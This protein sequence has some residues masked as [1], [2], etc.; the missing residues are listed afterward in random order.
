MRKIITATFITLDGVMQAPGGPE[1]DTS[2]GFKYGGWQA[3]VQWDEMMSSLLNTWMG[4]PFELL[5]G[6][7]TY[8]IF[9]A[10]WP[11]D[12][13]SPVVAKPFNSTKKYVVSHTAF[14]LSWH[15]SVC[16]TG[17]DVAVQIKKLKEEDGP[18]LWVWGSGNLIQT[19]L[20]HHLIDRMYLWIYPITIGSG[21]RLF[22]EGTQAEKF[23]L[24]DSKISTS[25]VIIA[26]YEPAGELKKGLSII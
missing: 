1:E 10:Y 24:T 14:E 18:D 3:N 19:L 2:G 5:L 6:K 22:V 16:I 13:T 7:R 9:A 15:N 8:D 17:N 26:T 4:L 21:Q 23:K 12:T 25:G 11:H 20:K